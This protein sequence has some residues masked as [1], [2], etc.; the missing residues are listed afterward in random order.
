MHG[1]G[2]RCNRDDE[3]DRGTGGVLVFNL[4][5]TIT[6]KYYIEQHF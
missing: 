4:S 5:S 3:R 6:T 2:Y 1:D